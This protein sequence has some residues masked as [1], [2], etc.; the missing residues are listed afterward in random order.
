MNDATLFAKQLTVIDPTDLKYGALH[1]VAE[2]QRD[3]FYRPTLLRER[4]S[5]CL[6]FVVWGS[7]RQTPL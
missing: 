2:I 1:K 7:L 6:E 4:R 3:I 5:S